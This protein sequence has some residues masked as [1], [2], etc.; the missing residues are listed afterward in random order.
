[1]AVEEYGERKEKEVQDG[2][3][4][5]RRRVLDEQSWQQQKDQVECGHIAHIKPISKKQI[6]EKYP[7]T[8]FHP[9]NVNLDN[10]YPPAPK[11]TLVETKPKRVTED[12]IRNEVHYAAAERYYRD[13][14]PMEAT[15]MAINADRTIRSNFI[16]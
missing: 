14:R 2:A 3:D 5:E 8:I 6:P 16:M 10:P 1:M 9:E 7:Y 12:D 13:V 4:Q 11:P 15:F